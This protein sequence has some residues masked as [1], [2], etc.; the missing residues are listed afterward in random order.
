MHPTIMKKENR[1][2]VTDGTKASALGAEKN[3]V[4]SKL[5]IA[6]PNEPLIKKPAPVIVSFRPFI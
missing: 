6:T 2:Y 5:P 1:K 4:F 3:K